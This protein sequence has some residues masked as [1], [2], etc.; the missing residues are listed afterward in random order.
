MS[1]GRKKISTSTMMKA[2]IP[3]LMKLSK[4]F[5]GYRI[6]KLAEGYSRDTIARYRNCWRLFTRLKGDIELSEITH[7]V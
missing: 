6:S 1:I 4:A 5:E 2:V 3:V 7:L